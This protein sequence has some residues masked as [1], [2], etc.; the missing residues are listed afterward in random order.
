M[1][2]SVSE[3]SR[4]MVAQLRL[5]DPN[6]SAEVGTPERLIIDTVAQAMN[7]NQIDLIGLENALNIETKFGSNLDNFLALFRF[8]RKEATY[9]KGYVVFTRN[10]PAEIPI[11][12][13]Q[14]TLVQ[15]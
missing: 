15:S 11:S 8:G 12:I 13:P 1:P 3:N 14:G 10:D 7:G 4:Q 5:L 9:S 6:Y 2:A